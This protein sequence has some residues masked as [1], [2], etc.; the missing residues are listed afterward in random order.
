MVKTQAVGTYQLEKRFKMENTKKKIVDQTFG[1]HN[2]V[3]LTML[4]AA[5]CYPKLITLTESKQ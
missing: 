2:L 4:E 3:K 5:Q 1:R